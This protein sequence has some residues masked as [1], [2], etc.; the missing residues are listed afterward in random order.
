VAIF[1]SLLC[2][3]DLSAHSRR[4]LDH[5]IRV[6]RHHGASLT[7]LYVIPPPVPTVPSLDSLAYPGYVYTPED[8]EAIDREV[9]AFVDAK[10]AGLRIESR[11]VQGYPVGEILDVAASLAADL[12]VV[13]THGRGGFQRLVLGSVAERVLAR[14]KCP[15]MAIPPHL[16]DTPPLGT[17]LFANILCGIDYSPSSNKALEYATEF[18]RESG[19]RLT[20]VHVVESA[21]GELA[22]AAGVRGIIEESVFVTAAR[23]RLH[24]ALPD[25]LVEREGGFVVVKTGKP[26]RGIIDVAQQRHCDLIVLGA[27]GG[28]ANV[29]GLGSTT[30]HV[31]REANCPV[32]TVRA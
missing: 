4:A 8:L 27:H 12:I 16:P 18:S 32:F 23:A 31:L 14:A 21:N 22:V 2:P 3:I 5:A 17:A 7:A 11:V 28:L 10:R 15:V 20:L 25:E 29:L 9:Q 13:G 30:N 24:A 19:G 6:G 26:Y 1:H